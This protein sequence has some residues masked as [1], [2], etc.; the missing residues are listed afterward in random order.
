MVRDA[1]AG[2]GARRGRLLTMSEKHRILMADPP[3]T[4]DDAGGRG[5][6]ARHY[7]CLSLLEIAVILDRFAAENATMLMWVVEPML[8]DCFKAARMAGFKR[9]ANGFTW[10]KT[11]QDGERL[12]WGMGHWSRA[13]PESCHIFTRGKKFPRARAHNVHSVVHAPAMK[14]SEK[15]AE[16]R[17]RLERMMG[18]RPRLELFARERVAGWHSW[19][20]GVDE[21]LRVLPPPSLEVQHAAE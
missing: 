6:A 10:I 15:P 21:Q 13:N 18:D 2:V 20:L 9:R 17:H 1:H 5:S 19:G 14:H 7:Q 12:H 8:E 11:T 16:V 4:Y 3:W